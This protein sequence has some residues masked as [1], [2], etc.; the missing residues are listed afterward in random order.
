MEEM[1]ELIIRYL[2]NVKPAECITITNYT[3]D[4]LANK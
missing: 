3:L 2:G 4:L 1:P